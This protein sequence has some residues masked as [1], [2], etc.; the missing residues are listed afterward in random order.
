MKIKE[1]VDLIVDDIII[2]KEI[3]E[4]IKDTY[5][6]IYEDI[7]KGSLNN[8]PKNILEMK[9]RTIGASKKGAIEIQVS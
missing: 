2:Y 8:I 5:E 9:I 6:D 1:L 3:N 4:E 7:Y